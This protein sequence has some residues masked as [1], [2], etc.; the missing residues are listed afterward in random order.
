MH[1]AGIPRKGDKL[2]GNS[3]AK[4]PSV[5][6]AWEG[7]RSLLRI[8]LRG[9]RAGI[10]AQAEDNKKPASLSA[11]GSDHGLKQIKGGCRNPATTFTELRLDGRENPQ[12]PSM[13]AGKPRSQDPKN[14]L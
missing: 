9:E 2:V 10:L 5:T 7:I 1:G 6:A 12:P 8:D 11:D 14:Y 4:A 13:F 3:V